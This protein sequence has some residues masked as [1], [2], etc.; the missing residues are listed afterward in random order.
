MESPRDAK[1]YR[2][3]DVCQVT[4]L[5][6][7]SRLQSLYSFLPVTMISTTWCISGATEPLAAPPEDSTTKTNSRKAPVARPEIMRRQDVVRFRDHLF[8]SLRDFAH[9]LFDGDAWTSEPP[10]HETLQ[11]LL[12]EMIC[13]I[14]RKQAW[15]H[16][17][18]E[19]NQILMTLL[20]V[21]IFMTELIA[22][23]RSYRFYLGK[24]QQLPSQRIHSDGRTCGSHARLNGHDSDER[25]KQDQFDTLDFKMMC[26]AKSFD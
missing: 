12:R 16:R 22:A 25:L 1:E 2:F 5:S 21:V 4:A 7:K 14:M 8:S 17:L 9:R 10:Q 15:W 18:C 19:T 6:L 24:T 11:G 3:H 13:P 26:I 20:T 23:S